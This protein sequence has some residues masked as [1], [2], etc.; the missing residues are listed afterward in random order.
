MEM[1]V[2]CTQPRMQEQGLQPE[3][4]RVQ[5]VPEVSRSGSS[6]CIQGQMHDTHSVLCLSHDMPPF[7]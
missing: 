5:S 1:S 3:T 6:A 7:R 4:L 2:S